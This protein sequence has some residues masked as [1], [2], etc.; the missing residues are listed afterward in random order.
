MLFHHLV[1]AFKFKFFFLLGNSAPAPT[2]LVS[3]DK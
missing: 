2:I 3:F 1:F